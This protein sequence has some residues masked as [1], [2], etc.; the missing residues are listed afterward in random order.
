MEVIR[1][2]ASSLLGLILLYVS[3]RGD[4][5]HIVLRRMA[6]AGG[7]LLQAAAAFFWIRAAGVEFGAIYAVLMPALL[8]WLLVL[9]NHELRNGNQ[10]TVQKVRI[11][12]PDSGT[13]SRHA[14]QLVLTIPLAGA[15]A[16]FGSAAIAALLP[17]NPANDLVLALILMPVLWGGGAYWCCADAQPLRPA[18]SLSI[19]TLASLPLLYL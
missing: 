9:Y 2:I 19:L 7:W 3:W 10:R 14:L 1:A 4:W 17:W 5:Q 6:I 12:I 11:S 16:A 15:A 8:A 13:I 18:L